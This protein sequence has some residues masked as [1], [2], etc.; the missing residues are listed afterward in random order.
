MFPAVGRS[1]F[2]TMEVKQLFFFFFFAA[3][4]V[5]DLFI[6]FQKHK[7]MFMN[8]EISGTTPCVISREKS[9]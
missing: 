3:L 8:C 1:V 7:K 5:C 9:V 6:N 4:E 2:K